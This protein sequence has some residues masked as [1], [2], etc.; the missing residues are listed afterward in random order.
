MTQQ[1]TERLGGD[2][3]YERRGGGYSAQRRADP[4]MA[5]QIWDCLG[6]ARSV[7]NVGAGTGNYEPTD[8]TIIALEPAAAMRAQR[9]ND[10]APCV[11]G[12]AEA[13]PF[14]DNSFDA[15]MSVLSVHQWRDKAKGLSE[16]RRVARD[17]VVLLTFDPVAL[18]Q[19]WQTNYMAEIATIEASRF[20]PIEDLCAHLGGAVDVR[21]CRV[22]QNCTDGFMEAF[23]SRPEHFLDPAVRASQSAWAFAPEGAE[24][25]FVQ[26]L[27]KD[28]ASGAW[29]AHYGHLR[30]APF[31]EGSLRLLVARV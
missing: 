4:R 5:A 22:P 27:S 2:Y 14:D 10:A 23:Y 30:N 21:M 3:D 8:R 11:I 29:D 12:V 20:L 9:P 25:R 13:L 1:N 26:R 6:P 31:F 28:L 24:E 19:T 15:V 18:Q 16:M 17:R 7:L